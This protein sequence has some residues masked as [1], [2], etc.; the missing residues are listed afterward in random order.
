MKAKGE[1]MDI[2]NIVTEDTQRNQREKERNWFIANPAELYPA[3]IAHIQDR[4][5]A[6][7]PG[8]GI[9]RSQYYPAAAVLPPRAW[10]L[11]LTPR[12][13]VSAKDIELRAQALEIARRWFTELLH[14]ALRWKAA[15]VESPVLWA[16]EPPQPAAAPLG[17]RI[18]KDED[19]RL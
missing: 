2:F 14:R 15:G 5:A 1:I 6:G 19:W 17:L 10:E 18:E 3:A 9:I 4:L 12:A 8:D 13:E 7:D 16:T 11:A